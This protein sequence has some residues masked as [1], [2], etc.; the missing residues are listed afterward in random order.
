L[1][2]ISGQDAV[3]NPAVS[4]NDTCQTSANTEHYITNPPGSKTTG[5]LHFGFKCLFGC[6]SYTTYQVSNY[7][8][9]VLTGVAGTE[10]IYELNVYVPGPENGYIE[11]ASASDPGNPESAQGPFNGVLLDAFDATTGCF[12]DTIPINAIYQG[13]YPAGDPPLPLNGP[14]S[15]PGITLLIN[16][17]GFWWTDVVRTY[18]ATAPYYTLGPIIYTFNK[19]LVI[20]GPLS[21][22][23]SNMSVYTAEQ[24]SN[25]IA[26]ALYTS[27][28]NPFY[29]PLHLSGLT[30]KGKF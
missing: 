24:N 16:Q 21:Y 6:T 22:V 9:A 25:V 30:T 14:S 27:K 23:W 18:Q 20:S 4:E 3:S 17:L 5:N 2:S 12:I 26:F 13:N 7:R 10:P 29:V 28:K 1:A 15:N 19:W 8:T 11:I